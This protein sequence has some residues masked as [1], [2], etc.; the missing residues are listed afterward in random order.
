MRNIFHVER[1]KV[2]KPLLQF[3]IPI[4]FSRDA[5][6]PK[7]IK[8]V[9]LCTETSSPIIFLM[10]RKHA[11]SFTE[12]TITVHIPVEIQT[13]KYTISTFLLHSNYVLGDYIESM[14]TPHEI[15]K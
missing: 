14:N 13:Q 15:T 11:D 4:H 12:P 6:N 1:I 10:F 9:R 2:M 8:P 3:S 7:N 5:V